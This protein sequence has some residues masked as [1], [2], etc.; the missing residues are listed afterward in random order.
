MAAQLAGRLGPGRTWPTPPTTPGWSRR[1]PA[2]PRR[3]A[4]PGGSAA[5]RAVADALLDLFWDDAVGR[6]VHHRRTTPSAL[7]ARPKDSLGRRRARRPTRSPPSPCCAW[8]PSPARPATATAGAGDHAG[9]LSRLVARRPWPSPDLVAAA[10]LA[11]TGVTEV[12]VTG[13]R[14]DLVAAVQAPLPA[15]RRAGLGG[16]VPVTAVGGPDRARGGGPGLR[17]P[18]L[19]LPGPAADPGTLWR[20]QLAQ[21]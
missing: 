17:L 8:P 9:A 16:A 6:P 14:P 1:S 15:R 21:G 2:W 11:R 5:A 10:D 19:H 4:R 13:D 3:P 12:V 7:I 18:G 20:R